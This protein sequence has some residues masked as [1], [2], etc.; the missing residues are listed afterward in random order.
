MVSSRKIAN[1]TEKFHLLIGSFA[2][3]HSEVRSTSSL[4]LRFVKVSRDPDSF[5]IIFDRF[6]LHMRFSLLLFCL[7]TALG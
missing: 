2:Y 1:Y 5:L 7:I 3:P 6:H 4:H